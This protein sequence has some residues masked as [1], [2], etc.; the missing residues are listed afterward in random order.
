MIFV[1][2][3]LLY[4]SCKEEKIY[5]ILTVIMKFLDYHFVR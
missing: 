2:Y 5:V 4:C 3:W 1:T